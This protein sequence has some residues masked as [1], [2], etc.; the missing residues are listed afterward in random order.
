[1]ILQIYSIFDKAVGAHLQPFFARSEGEAL[2][3]IRSAVNTADTQFHDNPG[4]FVLHHHGEF[5]DQTGDIT[6]IHSVPLITLSSLSAG[7]IPE[8][9]PTGLAQQR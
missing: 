5:H 3:M 1:M 4:D 6:A 7:I 8:N 9:D 2:R